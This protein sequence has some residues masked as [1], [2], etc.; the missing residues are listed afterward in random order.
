LRELFVNF[1]LLRNWK[2]NWIHFGG[3]I[4]MVGGTHPKNCCSRFCAIA[5]IHLKKK[6]RLNDDNHRKCLM[7]HTFN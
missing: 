4:L 3:R 7:K 5:E 1:T 6:V 2:K